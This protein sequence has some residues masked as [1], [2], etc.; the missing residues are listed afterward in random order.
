MQQFVS[1]GA[2]PGFHVTREA[3]IAGADLNPVSHGGGGNGF[4]Q[5]AERS[6][7]LQAHAVERDGLAGIRRVAAT[8]SV[9][10]L[11]SWFFVPGW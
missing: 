11:G 2:A 10:V 1:F 8:G 6:G 4:G 5:S 7:T 9:H 3:G